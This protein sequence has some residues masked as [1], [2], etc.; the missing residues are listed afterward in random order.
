MDWNGSS[1]GYRDVMKCMGVY[2][3]VHGC[4]GLK[5]LNFKYMLLPKLVDNYVGGSMVRI[6][7]Q[8]LWD[9]QSVSIHG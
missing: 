7:C 6:A 5:Y 9:F 1:W 8:N 4:D 2:R 3:G